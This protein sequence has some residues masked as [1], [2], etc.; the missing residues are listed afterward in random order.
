MDNTWKLELPEIPLNTPMVLE[1]EV[2]TDG[3]TN[4]SGVYFLQPSK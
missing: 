3:T 2:R 4:S 1:A